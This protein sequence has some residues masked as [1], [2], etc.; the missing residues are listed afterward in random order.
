MTLSP[1]V[2]IAVQVT[3]YMVYLAE[4][5]GDPGS[6]PVAPILLRIM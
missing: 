6:F 4:L 3:H 1:E 2:L 5:F